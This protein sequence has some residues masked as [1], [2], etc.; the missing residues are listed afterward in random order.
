[1]Q[2]LIDLQNQ[3]TILT[4]VVGSIKSLVS[5][6]QAQVTA[7][8]ATIAQ[9]GDNDADVEAQAQALGAQVAALNTLVNPVVSTGTGA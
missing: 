8:Q 4:T 3:V 9:G 6:L 7:L 2:G 1:M 5:G